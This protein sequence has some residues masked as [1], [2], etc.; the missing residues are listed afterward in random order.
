MATTSTIRPLLTV[1]ARLGECPLWD[2]ARQRLSWVD[3]YNH[4]VHQLD[5]VS[6]EHKF[7]EI[8]DV[9]SAVALTSSETLLVAMRDRLGLLQ[10][11]TGA[12]EPLCQVKFPHADLRFNDGMCDPQGRFWV[13]TTS[14][15]RGLAALYRFDRDRSI[16]VQ[17][18]GLTISN[19]LGF[20]PDGNTFYLTD[21]AA[22]K[23]Y[24]YR[25]DGR[26]GVLHDRRVLIDLE[27]LFEPGIEPDGL[28]VDQDGHLWCA[29]W[30]GWALVRFNP[31]GELVQRID[32]PVQRPTSLTF[33]GKDMNELYVTSASVGLSQ[34]EVQRGF[35]AGDLFR[36]PTEA[37]GIAEHSFALA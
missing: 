30:N 2:P 4:R 22:R 1:R 12:I 7:H 28:T 9:V 6:G 26:A 36:I 19:G 18:T 32:M 11:Q 23:I 5:P 21:S 16:Q 10:L 17:E 20:S 33:G 29:L 3:I 14:D 31:K 35:Y 13:G 34:A 27:G 37:R 24:A 15:H 8:D 25:F